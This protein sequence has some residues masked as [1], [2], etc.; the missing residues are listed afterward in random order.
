MTTE[1]IKAIKAL[2]II[3]SWGHNFYVNLLQKWYVDGNH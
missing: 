1:V 3:A 2:L